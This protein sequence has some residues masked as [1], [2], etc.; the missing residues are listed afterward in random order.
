MCNIH[1]FIVSF[2]LFRIQVEV[3]LVWVQ[4]GSLF[5]VEGQYLSVLAGNLAQAFKCRACCVFEFDS[6]ELSS[7]V[8]SYKGLSISYVALSK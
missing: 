2:S 3:K 6:P 5:Y 4:K 1:L 8:L 7:V